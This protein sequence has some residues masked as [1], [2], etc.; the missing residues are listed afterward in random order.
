MT[1]RSARPPASCS[2]SSGAIL[3]PGGTRSDIPEVSDEPATPAGLPAC[4]P[5]PHTRMVVVLLVACCLPWA[6]RQASAGTCWAG[7][8]SREALSVSRFPCAAAT[9]MKEEEAHRS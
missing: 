2:T 1:G 6:V 3:S 8:T 4:H 7:R 5:M 9:V